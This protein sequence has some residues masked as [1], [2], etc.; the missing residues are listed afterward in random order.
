MIRIKETSLQFFIGAAPL[1]EFRFHTVFT[2]VF[3][4]VPCD[5][6]T[7]TAVE[8]FDGVQVTKGH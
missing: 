2:T 1:H 8:T 4:A 5:S 3:W 7:V 6:V